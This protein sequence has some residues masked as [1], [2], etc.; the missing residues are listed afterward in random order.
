MV[1]QGWFSRRWRRSRSSGLEWQQERRRRRAG[2][3]PCSDDYRDRQGHR[4]ELEPSR[5]WCF[6][7]LQQ[8]GIARAGN[9]TGS[10]GYCGSAS[11][12]LRQML[13]HG[14]EF[15]LRATPSR[16][17]FDLGTSETTCGHES[18][19]RPRAAS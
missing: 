1:W 5:Q 18:S 16:N 13:A 2:V 12:T 8:D 9:S 6:L 10:R 14:G 15:F 3:A 19:Y 17:G 4:A 11:S 7:G